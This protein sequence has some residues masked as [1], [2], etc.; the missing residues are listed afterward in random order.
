M[1]ERLARFC[2][3]RRGR[4]LAAWIVALVVLQGAAG[5]IGP[6]W[7][8]DQSL[9]DSESQEV[10]DL[11]ET[12][13]PAQAGFTGQIV[14]E[15]DQ[16]I[17]D[18]DVQA[19]MEDLFADVEALDPG[20]EVK[21]P[22]SPEGAEQV[23]QVAP[24]AFAEVNVSDRTTRR[25]SRSATTSRISSDGID[26]EGLRIEFGGE[27]FAEFELPASEA[28]GHPR[29]D[30]HPARRVRFGRG[31]GP[32]DR[33]RAVRPRHRRRIDDA[34]SAACSRCPTSRRS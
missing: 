13:N 27:M 33:H 31:D 3:R 5:A 23:S 22:Y 11:L 15:A 29:G 7:R 10:Q 1:L 30:H 20:V 19:A 17:D 9:P 26:V 21:S 6:D 28:L 25:W 14:F 2:F 12:A 16:G 4:V 34:R 8:A 32:A 18:P 24:I